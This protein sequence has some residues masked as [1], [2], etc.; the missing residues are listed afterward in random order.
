MGEDIA[1]AAKMSPKLCSSSCLAKVNS[2]PRRLTI[3][4][5]VTGFSRA[6]FSASDSVEDDDMVVVNGGL[7]LGKEF[8]FFSF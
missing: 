2:P 6:W 7:F 3:L 5:L 1:A 4:C 8:T